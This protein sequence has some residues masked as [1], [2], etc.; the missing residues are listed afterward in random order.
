MTITKSNRPSAIVNWV[1]RILG[2]I[3]IVFFLVFL[4][5][6]AV[7]SIQQGYEFDAESLFI[8]LPIVLALAGYILSWWHKVIGGSLLILVSIIFGILVAWGAQRHQGPTS[9]YHA[10]AGW[11]I[12]GL[13]F[14]VVGGLF[15]ISAYLDRKTS[16]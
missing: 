9:D 1:A 12:L 11:L 4:I 15:L 3:V 8:I 7:D 13:P 10:L 5:G 14:L 16:S 6:D 2:L